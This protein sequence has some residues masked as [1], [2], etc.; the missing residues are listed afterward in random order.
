MIVN[1]SPSWALPVSQELMDSGF[2]NMTDTAR[3][4]GFVS[5]AAERPFDAASAFRIGNFASR[6]LELKIKTNEWM[7]S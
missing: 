1:S 2:Q 4:T 7:Y 3:G 6:F 5:H